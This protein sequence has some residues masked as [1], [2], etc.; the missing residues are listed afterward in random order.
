MVYHVFDISRTRMRMR[1]CMRTACT[2]IHAEHGSTW[3]ADGRGF[4]PHV[5]QKF[6]RGDLVMKNLYGHSLP[7]AESRGA[8]DSYWRKNVHYS[9]GKLPRRLAQEQRV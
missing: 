7:S 1:V 4:D 8:V 3:Y 6:F 2:W 9:I 5:Q